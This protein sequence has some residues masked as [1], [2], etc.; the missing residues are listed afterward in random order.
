MAEYK[1]ILNASK[2]ITTVRERKE[3]EKA[4]TERIHRTET[5]RREG[6]F[7]SLG[8][9]YFDMTKTFALPADDSIFMKQSDIENLSKD[10][11]LVKFIEVEAKANEIKAKTAPTLSEVAEAVAPREIKEIL[12]APKEII[13]EELFDAVFEV[14]GTMKQLTALG[15]YMKLNGITYKNI[16]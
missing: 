16:D 8:M 2:A 13:K 14:S 11:F 3:K 4:E 5:S 9:V 10:E 7:R 12:Q 1:S 6:L 15:E